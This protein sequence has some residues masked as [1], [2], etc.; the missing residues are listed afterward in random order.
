M[1]EIIKSYKGYNRDMACRGKKYEEG[2]TYEEEHAS[3]C[4]NG[5]HACEYPLDCFNYYPPASSVY[6]EVEQSGKI[7][8]SCDDSKI[9][10]TKMKI[11]A[12]LDIKGL[13]SAAVEF[14][15]SRT[16]FENS[17]DRKSVV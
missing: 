13:V 6:G 16:N 14:T 5:M 1:G 4:N 11:G 7:D 2:K 8:K 12:K 17:E 9:A 3:V 15:K 10:S